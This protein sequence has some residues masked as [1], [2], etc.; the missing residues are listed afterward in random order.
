[1]NK[2]IMQWPNTMFYRDKLSA[3]PLVVN[4]NLSD[5]DNVRRSGQLTDSVL[6]LMDTSGSGSS[7]QETFFNKSF[8][9]KTEA[10]L[11][12][13]HLKDLTGKVQILERKLLI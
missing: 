4:H 13:E 8:Y 10:V 3:A 2:H 11:V 7:R 6:G 9:N 12:M 5:L 1:M